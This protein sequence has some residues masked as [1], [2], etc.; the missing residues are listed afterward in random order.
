MYSLFSAD[1]L[2][3]SLLYNCYVLG[4]LLGAQARTMNKKKKKIKPLLSRRQ[5]F[6]GDEKD[7]KQS[8]YNIMYCGYHIPSPHHK[9]SIALSISYAIL[10]LLLNFTK[11]G[12]SYLYLIN[13]KARVPRV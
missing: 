7:K 3:K 6:K 4:T 5:H 1:R 11:P 2:R 8:N 9:S 12:H 10:R 13:G